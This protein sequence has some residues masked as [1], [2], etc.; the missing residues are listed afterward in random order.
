MI[1]K[2]IACVA[3]PEPSDAQEPTTEPATSGKVCPDDYEGPSGEDFCYKAILEA[4]SYEDAKRRCVEDNPRAHLAYA[5]DSDQNDD[6][7]KYLTQFT[8][9]SQCYIAG[10]SKEIYYTSGQRKYPEECSRD[11]SSRTNKFVWKVN[12]T[13]TIEYSVYQHWRAGEPNC[14]GSYGEN[15]L[16]YRCEDMDTEATRACYWNDYYCALNACLLCQIDL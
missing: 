2:I 10:A 14:Y 7:N 6:I 13:T 11:S 12:S 9:N 16:V 4:M 1:T 15:C 5:L 3:E 8:G